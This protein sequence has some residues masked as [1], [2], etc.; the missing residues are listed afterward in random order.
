MDMRTIRSVLL[1]VLLQVGVAGGLQAQ[2]PWFVSISA[3]PT[4]FGHAAQAGAPGSGEVKEFGPAQGL[5]GGAAA[6]RR[7]G[8]WE[9]ALGASIG[10]HGLRGGNG[11]VWVTVDPAYDLVTADVTGAYAFVTTSSGVRVQ[12]FAGPSLQFWSGDAVAGSRTLLG[13]RG[14]L[15]L[16]APITGYLQLDTRAAIGVSPSPVSQ[17]ELADLD[18]AY[19]TGALWSRELGVGLRVSF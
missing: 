6:G 16:V 14:G 10:D 1:P 3:L 5:R 12:A 13:A 9:V 2:H 18:S 19:D 4:A 17:E 15:Q 11:E 8:R 7:F